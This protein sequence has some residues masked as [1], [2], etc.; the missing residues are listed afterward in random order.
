MPRKNNSV[1]QAVILLFLVFIAAFLLS[2]AGAKSAEAR[3][4]RWCGWYMRTQVS[5]DPGASFNL[6]RNW[7]YFGSAAS[8]PA[9]G[10]IVVWRHHVGHIVGQ[11]ARGQWL[12]HS[13]NDGGAVRTRA[14]SLSGAIAFRWPD[15]KM[16][17]R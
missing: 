9:K 11:N 14:R 4:Y 7:A 17:M 3:P 1:V 13:G 16:A 2:I 15:R 12:V 5:H 6:A 10:V 8:G